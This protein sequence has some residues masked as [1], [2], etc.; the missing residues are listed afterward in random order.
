MIAFPNCK[1]NLGLRIIGKRA[2]GYH[3]IETIF[4]PLAI[5]D[6]LEI[7]SSTNDQ[8]EFNSSG[9]TIEGSPKQ[10]FCI[11]AYDLLKKLFPDIPPVMMHLHKNIP[12]G[13]GL[14]GGSADG[15]FTLQLLNKLFH[16]GVSIEK[17]ID[18]ALQLGSDCP[19]FIINKPC[20]GRGRGEMLE[21][22]QVDLSK[23]TIYIVNPGIHLNTASVFK[24]VSKKI[25]GTD[26][27]SETIKSP[28]T[29]WKD[30]LVN[31]LESVVFDQYPE[32]KK[33]K[34]QLY[35]EGALYASMS[36]SGSTVFGIFENDHTFRIKFPPGYFIKELPGQ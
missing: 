27:L 5:N 10:N 1:I 16:L 28:V 20:I 19:F 32:I 15:A 35:A 21:K 9:L 7:I 4:Y 3:N 36:G 8:V 6:V 23:Y 26:P 34:E 13:A 2:D 11:L 30:H 22:T 29:N 33:I 12:I 25:S 18:L 17:L 14:G 24:V 31:E